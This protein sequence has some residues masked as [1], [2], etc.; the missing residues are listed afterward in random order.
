M[1][2]YTQKV[3]NANVLNLVFLAENQ[4]TVPVVDAKEDNYKIGAKYKI[5]LVKDENGYYTVVSRGKDEN[6]YFVGISVAESI[7][8]NAG[9]VMFDNSALNDLLLPDEI[10][11]T[12]FSLIFDLSDAAQ[13]RLPPFFIYSQSEFG[14]LKVGDKLSIV[15]EELNESCDPSAIL[16][17][18]QVIIQPNNMPIIMI[19]S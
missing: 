19:T 13:S 9:R 8:R 7:L 17:S 11:Q 15:I 5:G 3:F 6:G 18:R 16:R 2:V 12:I 4:F 1:G 14:D 10:K